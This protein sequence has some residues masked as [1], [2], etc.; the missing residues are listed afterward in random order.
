[1]E[2]ILAKKDFPKFFDDLRDKYKIIGPTRKGSISAFTN[3]TIDYIDSLDELE[4]HYTE[5]MLPLK[6]ILFPDSEI[7][8]RYEKENSDVKLEDSMDKW[9]NKRLFLGIH[10]CDITAVSHLDKVLKEEKFEDPFYKN[11]RNNSIIIGLTCKE[12]GERCFCNITGS[13]PDI[14]D[15]FDLLMTDIGDSYYVKSGSETGNSLLESDYFED[16]TDEQM[17]EREKAIEKVRDELPQ[18]LE[19]EGLSKEMEKRYNDKLWNEFSEKCETCG[20]C[21]IVCPTCHCFTIKERTNANQSKGERVRTWDSCHFK[22][23]AEMAGGLNIREEKTSR[24]KHRMYDKFYYTP[25]RYDSIFCVGCGRCI[26]FCQSEIDIREA[27][28]KVMEA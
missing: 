6:N 16:A 25:M 17:E 14:E 13:G 1:M 2:K 5:T 27:L 8:Y 22:R 9:D 11:R 23:F 7:L 15:G 10:P 28:R 26:K 19:I 12:A 24:F 20:N 18:D 4:L 3:I 21:N